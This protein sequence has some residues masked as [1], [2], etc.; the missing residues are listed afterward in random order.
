MK[1]SRKSIY[2]MILVFAFMGLETISGSMAIAADTVKIG[3]IFPVSGKVAYDGQAVVTGANAAISYINEKGGILGGRKVELDLIDSVCQ[4]AQAVSAAKRLIA[5]NDT[6]VII[7]DFCSNAT[8]ALQ[9]VTE[10]SK[11]VL[12]TPVAVSP[13]LTERG[14]KLFFRNNSTSAMHSKTFSNFV[15]KV[16]KLK[17][18]ALIVKNDEYGQLETKIYS[19]LYQELGNPKVVYSG[20]FGSADVDFSAQLTQA[21][22]MKTESIYIVAQ[23]EQGANI[24]KQLRNLGM[25]NVKILGAGALFNPKLVELVG[26][27]AEGMYVYTGYDPSAKNPGMKLFIEEFPKRSGKEC[28]LYE[29]MGWDTMLILANAID[30][31]GTDKDSAK[32]ADRLRQSQFDGPRGLITFDGNGQAQITTKIVQVQKGKFVRVY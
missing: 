5:Q 21:K 14:A 3:M 28:G 30:K 26:E 2:G 15:S 10:E 17:T 19:Q 11:V 31:A 8:S 4:P 7:G 9:Q 22:S 13:M 6:K 1:L 18:I 23:T 32:I 29:A 27:G 24:I 25:T 20:F 16:L 12:I